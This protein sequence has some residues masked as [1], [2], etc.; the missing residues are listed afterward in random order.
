MEG[1]AQVAPVHMMCSDVIVM[2]EPIDCFLG[3]CYLI[4]WWRHQM[5]TFSA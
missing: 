1:P 2:I 4:P 5:E 3:L